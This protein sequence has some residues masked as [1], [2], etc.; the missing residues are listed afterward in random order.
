MSYTE[1]TIKALSSYRKITEWNHFAK[2]FEEV[3]EGAKELGN[4]EV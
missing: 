4:D 2:E 3:Y 1:R